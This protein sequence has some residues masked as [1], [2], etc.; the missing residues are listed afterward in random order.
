MV[1]RLRAERPH[2]D[3][4]LIVSAG[5]RDANP[6]VSNL[7]GMQRHIRHDVVIVAD[8]DIRVA[9]D[10]VKIVT[11]ALT[12][13]RVGLVTCLYRGAGDNVWARLAAM[14]IDYRFLPDVLVGLRVGLARPGFGSTL[15]AS[16]LDA[17]RDRRIRGFSGPACG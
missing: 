17:G 5:A 14:A 3:L 7:V 13:P 1:E 16:P 10:Y 12:E 6:K 4:E 11:A 2:L 15:A 9:P 8:S